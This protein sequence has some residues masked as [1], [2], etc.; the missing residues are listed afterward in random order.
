MIIWKLG[1][2]YTVTGISLTTLGKNDFLRVYNG[3]LYVQ[4]RLFSM[5]PIRSDFLFM[6]L[7][8]VVPSFVGGDSNGLHNEGASHETWMLSHR[9]F[10]EASP[11]L[12]MNSKSSNP[13]FK[14]HVKLD[15]SSC[16]INAYLE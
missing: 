7:T 4:T 1:W 14:F 2:F 6:V 5:H 10:R 13:N 3:G 16:M 11:V 9:V 8:S 12:D 15:I